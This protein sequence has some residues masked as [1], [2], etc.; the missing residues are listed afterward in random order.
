MK[1]PLKLFVEQLFLL[2]FDTLNTPEKKIT[3]NKK[4]TVTM[5]NT[6]TVTRTKFLK[7][8]F[9]FPVIF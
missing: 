4:T 9:W 7:S 1:L 5:V 2:F 3:H 6:V 8:K